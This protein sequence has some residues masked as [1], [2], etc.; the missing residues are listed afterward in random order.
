MQHILAYG[1]PSN[2]THDRRPG[3][4]QRADGSA[5]D[6]YGPEDHE[7]GALVLLSRH[8]VIHRRLLTEADDDEMRAEPKV[9][10][11]LNEDIGQLS[12]DARDLT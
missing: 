2:R 9:L 6:D 3:G 10:D 12:S 8:T 1:Q 11:K 5:A 4:Q 7:Y